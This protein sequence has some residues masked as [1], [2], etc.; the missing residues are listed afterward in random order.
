MIREALTL[1]DPRTTDATVAGT[2]AAGLARLVAAGFDV[3]HAVV[4]PTDLAGEWSVGEPPTWVR[5][6]VESLCA[7]VGGPLTVR[8]SATWEDGSTRAHAGAT[9]TVL[10]VIGVDATLAATRRCLDDTA[11]AQQ[12]G[13]AV[14]NVAVILQ[15]LIPA[16]WAGV[17]F[18]ADP[19]TGDRDVVRIAATAGLGEALVQGEV[20][21]SDLVVRGDT[22]EGD[23]HGF[24]DEDVLA[25]AKLARQIEAAFGRPQDIEWAVVDG[26]VH[27]LQSR[28]IT[29]LPVAPEMPSGNNWQKD[30]AHYPEPLT[31]FGWSVFEST[32]EVI[33]SVFDEVGM[34]IRGLEEHSAGGEIYGRVLPAF[35]SPDDAGSPPPAV[36]LGL[37]ARIVPALRRRAATARAAD[38][39]DLLGHWERDWPEKD[40]PAM[41]ARNAELAAAPLAELDDRSLAGHLDTLH[42]HLC[43][44]MKI[45]FRLV[46]PMA[47]HL[48]RLHRLVGDELGWADH[49]IA[50]MLAGHSPASRAAGDA[51][52]E[53]GRRV[54]AVD[55][56]AAVD[57]SRH[58]PLG[59]LEAI[60]P[61]LAADVG[62]WADE[63][64]WAMVN[65]DAGVATLAERPEVL[66]AMLIDSTATDRADDAAADADDAAARA[67]LALA[68]GKRA[69]FDAALAAARSIYGVREDNTIVVGD[70]PMALV[71]RWML[72]VSGRLVAK[73]VLA[74]VDDAAYL[75]LDELR[76]AISGQPA[77]DLVDR[78][79]RR[80][81]EEAYVRA[82]PGPA[83]IGD[84]G[85]AP[86]VSRLPRALREINEP[87]LWL[88]GHEYPTPA[89]RPDDE[90]VVA[91]GV[92]A[93]P[94]LAEGTVRVIRGHAEMHRLR[95]GDV[96]V[97]QVTSPSWAPLFPLACA[98]VADGGGALS[99]AAIA[100]R[101]HGIPAVLGTGDGTK[102]LTDGQRVRVDGTRGL[103]FLPQDEG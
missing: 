35:G 81:G 99:H 19:L 9:T 16:Q 36:I 67:R 90:S 57:R 79:V 89:E 49:E 44:G 68:P 102:T 85:D 40:R 103:V 1:D 28:P 50:A 66:A 45:H 31:P 72:E 3:P 4:L 25:V 21:G 17:A 37:A 59:A 26:K 33:A 42:A 96:L 86:D 20:I 84:Q 8:S 48:Y 38:A 63:H 97:C 69:T 55:G 74:H 7:D 95:P 13:G 29:I 12:A 27:V 76:D 51:M 39:K 58:D 65:Y 54:A 41:V 98:V 60:D 73:G 64:G 24:G 14:G 88:V 101:E 80:R 6:A 15:R 10:D 77:A 52:A 23:R 91:A 92:P 62:A 100:A 61:T 87:V 75:T 5:A 71:R 93:S 2:K 22:I 30:T 43:R 82:N 32:K 47:R 83:Y 56:I 53:L 78:I 46:M 94:G 18:T 34:L 11:T 70:R